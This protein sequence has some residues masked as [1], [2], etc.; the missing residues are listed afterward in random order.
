MMKWKFLD[1]WNIYHGLL[2][3]E[4]FS[5]DFIS[6]TEFDSFQKYSY[7]DDA[8][9]IDWK[10]SQS[11]GKKVIKK[12]S[13]TR[14]LKVHIEIDSESFFCHPDDIKHTFFQETFTLIVLSVFHAHWKVIISY[15]NTLYTLCEIKDLQIWKNIFHKEKDL[16]KTF[17]IPQHTMAH[18]SAD[19]F[20]L[21][22]DSIQQSWESIKS[23]KQL[24][25][26]VSSDEEI[27]GFSNTLLCFENKNI[28]W[29]VFFWKNNKQLYIKK[30]VDFLDMKQKE[31]VKKQITLIDSS[32]Y[33]DMFLQIQS[34]LL[35]K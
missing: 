3:T 31:Y 33:E 30:R 23:K 21:L 24:Y 10:K 32:R 28:T 20:F 22:T 1:F 14:V 27:N 13:Q 16:M 15:K 9:Q 29:E 4:D 26:C 12:M 34:A 18:Q 35:L 6:G 8:K 7:A 17:E 25:I 11:I 5:R 2:E 19:V